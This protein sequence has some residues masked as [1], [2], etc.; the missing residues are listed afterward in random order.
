MM[1]GMEHP[2]VVCLNSNKPCLK[3]HEMIEMRFLHMVKPWSETPSMI[4]VLTV[5][6]NAA[7]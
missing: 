6:T 3:H 5:G 1:S 2:E 4:S 7:A